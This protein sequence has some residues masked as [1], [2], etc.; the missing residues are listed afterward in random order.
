MPGLFSTPDEISQAQQ[1]LQEQSA[2]GFAGLG[3][4]GGMYLGMRAGQQIGGLL[5]GPNPAMVRS[6]LV[7]DA[8]KE[9]NQSGT[10]I[11]T[12]KY[13]ETLTKALAQRNLSNDALGVQQYGAGL[14]ATA[15][16]GNLE[17][18]QAI[19]QLAQAQRALRSPALEHLPDA[20]KYR[21]LLENEQA[22]PGGGN[23]QT[24]AF[25]QDM[26]KK[27]AQTETSPNQEAVAY[28]QET[29]DKVASGKQLTP[30]EIG[31]AKAY[32]FQ[33]TAPRFDQA[34]GQMI[35]HPGVPELNPQSNFGIT[36]GPQPQTASP[37]QP[38]QPGPTPSPA[39]GQ[40]DV[41]PRIL[42]Q[43]YSVYPGRQPGKELNDDVEKYA[44]SLEQARLPTFE[45]SLREVETQ[46][47]PL[48]K[49]AFKYLTGPQALLPDVIVSNTV[50]NGPEIVRARQAFARLKD[51]ELKDRSGATVTVPEFDRFKQEYGQG[52]LKTPEQ[53]QNAL[54]QVRAG[55]DRHYQRVTAGFDPKI[56]AEYNRRL[57]GLQGAT[58]FGAGNAPTATGPN[59]ERIILR[60]GRWIPM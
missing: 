22:K 26:M 2:R 6:L 8:L 14:E 16:K 35:M 10:E 15:A 48:G 37:A 54:D 41:T 46:L 45:S 18:A 11:G 1:A 25:Y 28:L 23:P 34:S 19:N 36:A 13:F 39:P 12:P 9:A 31:K 47:Q 52:I 33:L 40:Y 27:R 51:M 44:R 58:A 7:Q 4:E 60:N 24:I 21:V 59:G 29:R 42:P 3:A 30:N 32:Y 17:R 55:I 49:N 53:I 43:G 20:E 5:S 57:S 50:P 56:A 38:L